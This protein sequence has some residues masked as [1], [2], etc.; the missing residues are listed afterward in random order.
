MYARI[1]ILEAP[2]DGVPEVRATFQGSEQDA[3]FL[4][5]LVRA[6]DADAKYVVQA[7]KRIPSSPTYEEIDL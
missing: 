7:E 5:T 2:Y 4:N 3:R 1:Q 6:L